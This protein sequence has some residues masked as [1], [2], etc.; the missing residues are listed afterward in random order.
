MAGDGESEPVVFLRR[1][2]EGRNKSNS[3]NK[4]KAKQNTCDVRVLSVLLYHSN[5]RVSVSLFTYD[6]FSDRSSG[7]NVLQSDEDWRKVGTTFTP[8]PSM[9]IIL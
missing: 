2:R 9:P 1:E 3:K 4:G 6:G 5:R 7:Q 8:S